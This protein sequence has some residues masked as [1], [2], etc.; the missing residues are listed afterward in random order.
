MTCTFLLL[1]FTFFSFAMSLLHAPILGRSAV[2]GYFW[3]SIGQ[4]A[5]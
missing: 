3:A 2:L 4:L 1:L 5:Q